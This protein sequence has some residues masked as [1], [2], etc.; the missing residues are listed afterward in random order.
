MVKKPLK[1]LI[2]LCIIRG[3]EVYVLHLD[4]LR[5]R[6]EE[7]LVLLSPRRRDKALRRRSE[8]PRLQSVGA[9]LLLR[10][11]FGPEDPAVLPGGKPY[12][13]GGPCFS[14]THSG[15]LAAIALAESDVGLDAERIAPASEAV[16][17]RV[18][19]EKELAWLR[20]QGPEGF[21]FLWTRKEAALKC[22]GTGVDRPLA[23]V[24]VLSAGPLLLD[25]RALAL[26]SMRSG[27][28]M[29]SAASEK[30]AVFTPQVLTAEELLRMI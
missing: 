26:H 20:G 22:L 13:P 19:D 5:P 29:L 11:F 18:L 24:N 3:M 30:D 10:R 2:F 28:Y 23:S 12:Y 14:L 6:L 27:D 4:T 25:G 8:T 9:G 16:K 7:A 17:R 21:A 15:A 1:P